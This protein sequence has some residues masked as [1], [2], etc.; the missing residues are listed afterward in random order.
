MG[1]LKKK[2]QLDLSFGLIFSVILIIAFFGFAIYAIIKFLGM[3]DKIDTE[4][5]LEDLQIDVDKLWKSGGH[6]TVN[7]SYFLPTKIKEVCFINLNSPKKG[8]RI[9]IYDELKDWSGENSNLVFYPIG[10]SKSSNYAMIENIN[11]ENLAENPL[12]FK[13]NNGR[14]NI[15]LEQ[16][17]GG[18]ALVNVIK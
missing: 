15:T 11:T 1:D 4:R 2:G 6:G 16:E 7:P 8:T 13:N 14:I 17:T 18:T 10:S 12:C 5:F 9:G 3:K